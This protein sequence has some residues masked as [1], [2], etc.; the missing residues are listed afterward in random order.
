MLFD[1]GYEEGVNFKLG[2]AA[3]MRAADVILLPSSSAP[4]EIAQAKA[5]CTVAEDNG[6]GDRIRILLNRVRGNEAGAGNAREVM[7]AAGRRVLQAEIPY[8]VA[9]S[10]S[11]RTAPD[12]ARGF[13]GYTGVALEV[14]A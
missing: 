6:G 4:M 9:V 14:M 8:R 12:R 13:H 2:A 11:A 1:D 5:T 7:E 10:D 3:A